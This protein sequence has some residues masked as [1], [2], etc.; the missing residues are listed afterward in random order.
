MAIVCVTAEVV[1]S[2]EQSNVVGSPQQPR[3]RYAGDA[4]ADDR[5]VLVLIHPNAL[6]KPLY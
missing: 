3:G 4:A 1:V 6:F 2:L 5:N